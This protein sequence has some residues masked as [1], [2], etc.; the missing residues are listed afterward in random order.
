MCTVPEPAV[1]SLLLLAGL[2]GWWQFR[3][4]VRV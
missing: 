3:S 4:A 1:G 2:G